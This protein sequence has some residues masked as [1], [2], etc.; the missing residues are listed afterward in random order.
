MDLLQTGCKQSTKNIL[1]FI[2][3]LLLMLVLMLL[4]R[5]DVWRCYSGWWR[6][7]RFH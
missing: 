4:F 3:F 5:M 6:R 2:S 7:E 1:L